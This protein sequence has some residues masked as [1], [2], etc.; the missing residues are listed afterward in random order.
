LQ[1]PDI[2][3]LI[4]ACKIAN[5]TGNRAACYH[6]ARHY[7]NQEMFNEAVTYFAKAH[8]I[9]SAIRIARVGGVFYRMFRQKEFYFS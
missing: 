3:S 9:G 5:D 8:A 7:E 4:Q 1:Q 2:F 6:L